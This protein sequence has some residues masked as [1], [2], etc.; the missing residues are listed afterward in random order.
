MVKSRRKRC[1][2]AI[3]KI[4][5]ANC[6]YKWGFSSNG[7]MV[8]SKTDDESSILST[9]AKENVWVVF[10]NGIINYDHKIISI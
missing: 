7:R 2:K 4:V 5:F 1:N 6:L 3:V 10:D 9:P 8:V